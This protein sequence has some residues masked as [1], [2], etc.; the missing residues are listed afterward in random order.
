MMKGR[1]SENKSPLSIGFKSRSLYFLLRPGFKF[2]HIDFICERK[3]GHERIGLLPRRKPWNEI[4]SLL[5]SA[6]EDEF[7]KTASLVSQTLGEVKFRYRH[8]HQDS[9]VQAAFAYLIAL[10]TSKLPSVEGLASVDPKLE[11]NPSPL[12]ITVDLANWVKIHT[13]STEYAELACR[14]AADTISYWTKEKSNQQL[15]F[16]DSSNAV[17]IWR[18]I[19]GR[20]FS[21]ISRLFFAKLTERYVRYFIERSASAESPSIQ[22]RQRLEASL[23]AH[24]DE[25]SRHAFETTKITQSFAAGW[26]NK[27]TK[28]Q[29]PGDKEISGFL[30]VAF[31]KLHEELS[32]EG[33]SE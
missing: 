2:D 3:M 11:K 1:L 6:L 30:A 33:N 21:S 28:I 31:G 19:D 22:A 29:R 14:A 17:H 7:S 20:A 25:I 9:G 10:S 26:F 32:R 8:L 12:R 15:L 27:N 23:S 24:F 4:V 13:D 16:D 18:D 5:R